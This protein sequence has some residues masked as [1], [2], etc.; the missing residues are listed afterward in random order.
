MTIRP[1]RHILGEAEFF[2]VFLDDAFVPD[3][4]S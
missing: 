2:E 4:S 3:D 1:L